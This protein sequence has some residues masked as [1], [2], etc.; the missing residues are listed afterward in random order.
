MDALTRLRDEAGYKSDRKLAAELHGRL[1][2]AMRERVL[3]AS[4]AT[5]LGRIRKGDDRWWRENDEARA[6]LLELLECD[7][8]ELFPDR[9]GVWPFPELP[10]LR[11]LREGE[12]P[13][14]YGTLRRPAGVRD[15][16]VRRAPPARLTD[17]PPLGARWIVVPPGGGKTLAV[18]L[19]DR[20]TLAPMPVD[21]VARA[22]SCRAFE[23]ECLTDAL[24]WRHLEQPLIVAVRRPDPDADRER[25]AVHALASHAC[26]TILSR[27]DRPIGTPPAWTDLEWRADGAERARFFHWV[28]ERLP[29]DSLFDAEAATACVDGLDPDAEWLVAPRDLLWAAAVLHERGERDFGLARLAEAW[30]RRPPPGLGGALEQLRQRAPEYVAGLV[31][32]RLPVLGVPWTGGLS[33]TRWAGLVPGELASGLPLSRD[34]ARQ[35][36]E[37][38]V[39]E[40]RRRE[41]ASAADAVVETLLRP[42]PTELLEGASSAG[43]FGVARNGGWDLEPAWLVRHVAMEIVAGAVRG[44][45]PALW[46]AW[47]PDVARRRLVDEALDALGAVDLRRILDTCEPRIAE[48]DIGVVGAVEAVF[49]AVARRPEVDPKLAET[50]AR[51]QLAVVARPW[52]DE[53]PLPL[54]RAHDDAWVADCW[55]CSL[56]CPRPAWFASDGD[57]AWLFPGWSEAPLPVREAPR[58]VGGC[59]PIPMRDDIDEPLAPV[60]RALR[61]IERHP[62]SHR[63]LRTAARLDFDYAGAESTPVVLLVESIIDHALA[64]R[65]IPAAD[66]EEVWG[67][68]WPAGWLV[69]RCADEPGLAR[70]VG[71]ALWAACVARSKSLADVYHRAGEK[72]ELVAFLNAALDEDAVLAALER[73]PVNARFALDRFAPLLPEVLQPTVVRWL[74][75]RAPEALRHVEPRRLGR[76]ALEALLAAPGAD[77]TDARRL[78]E[79]FPRRALELIDE[80]PEDDTRL[81]RLLTTRPT[82]H[83]EAALARLERWSSATLPV[84]AGWFANGIP[85]RPDLAGRLYRLM[86]R[87]R[88]A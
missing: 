41:R 81:E 53:K 35:R 40:N 60:E 1:G 42:R 7:A 38:V 13:C 30:S 56:A 82:E 33:L 23:V 65:A 49:A 57:L 22:L 21:G 87:A 74:S 37:A 34:E 76:D 78:W 55:A 71:R 44:A 25:A 83:L 19:H 2:S 17:P 66:A 79:H 31:G 73:H 45:D 64:G 9:A 20:R 27:F 4:L 6:A 68:S 58:W 39:R 11:G 8:D 70:R 10:V 86:R 36:L 18:Q 3:P 14:P 62:G 88:P 43:F 16:D 54:T 50:A 72:P 47:C 48:V 29:A 59:V 51:L 15:W 77:W 32:A 28:A 26:L 80:L 69:H 84:S 5:M 61:W 63:L 52:S 67:Y 46:G 85:Q 75:T 24:R 12:T